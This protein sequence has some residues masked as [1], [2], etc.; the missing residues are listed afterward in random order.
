MDGGS[1]TLD[2]ALFSYFD[3]ELA[4]AAWRDVLTMWWPRLLPGIAAGATHGVIRVGHAVRALLEKETPQ[5]VG[6]LGQG[7]ASWA[8]RWQPLAP[9]GRG[10]Y[11]VGDPRAALDA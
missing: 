8:A 10:P 7:L 6:G 4:P 3:R 2:E 9:V 11:R 5:R 1:I